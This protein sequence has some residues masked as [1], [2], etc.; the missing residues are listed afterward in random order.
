MCARVTCVRV[1]Q[2]R[3]GSSVR[4]VV[5]TINASSGAACVRRLLTVSAFLFFVLELIC[6]N[7]NLI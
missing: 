2:V 1:H 6:R 3:V 4:S 7:L 5:I